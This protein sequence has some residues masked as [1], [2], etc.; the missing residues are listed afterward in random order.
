M[1]RGMTS[2]LSDLPATADG[3]I[4]A[5]RVSS[6][7]GH[8]GALARAEARG[9]LVRVHRGAYVAAD[10][11]SA[12]PAWEQF[13]LRCRAAAL[14]HPGIVLSHAAAAA[15]WGVPLLHHNRR[16]EV[17]ASGPEAGRVSGALH[18]RG[19]HLPASRIIQMDGITVTDLARTLAELGARATFA[20]AVTALDWG[21]H[22]RGT[23]RK[24]LTT[25]DV[26]RA[27]AVELG[28]VRGARRLARA[29]EFADGRSES[30][31]ESLS[32]VLI[33]ELGFE[34][35]DLQ[36]EFLLPQLGVV[37]TDFRWAQQQIVGEFDGLSKY[38]AAELRGGRTVEQVVVD[39]K[40]REDA[41]RREGEKVGRWIW[42]DL[43]APHRLGAVL[44]GLGVPQA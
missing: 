26:I 8:Q 42:A 1:L 2:F 19:T 17:L 4:L 24:P 5:R 38:R 15:M 40:L 9:E 23:Q 21:I 33:V 32:R 30:A 18:Y 14:A 6:I 7:H 28:I 27:A 3:V 12:A 16:I 43:W 10:T 11:W 31:G 44:Q 35:P 29:L 25:K 37:R 36:H 22:P 34:L 41:I 39:E 13:R 20:E